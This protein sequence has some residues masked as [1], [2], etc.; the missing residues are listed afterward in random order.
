MCRQRCG[1]PLWLPK[2]AGRLDAL[3]PG[4]VRESDMNGQ[5]SP[6]DKKLARQKPGEAGRDQAVKCSATMAFNCAAISE[7]SRFRSSVFTLI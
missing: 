6:V 2:G 3:P 7:K 1:N 4:G 5:G